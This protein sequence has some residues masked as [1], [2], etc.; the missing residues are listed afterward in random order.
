MF[1]S[2][3]L[4]NNADDDTT[5]R[6]I[7]SAVVLVSNPFPPSAI[8]TPMGFDDKQQLLHDSLPVSSSS[9]QINH[10]CYCPKIPATPFNPLTSPFLIPSLELMVRH[11]ELKTPSVLTPRSLPSQAVAKPL[12]LTSRLLRMVSL[13]HHQAT[14][15][16]LSHHSVPVHPSPPSASTLIPSEKSS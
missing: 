13:P 11:C 6:S 7:P 10:Y 8:A 15:N 3:L 16:E 5:V 12:A 2:A 4:G 14:L 1:Q 9:N